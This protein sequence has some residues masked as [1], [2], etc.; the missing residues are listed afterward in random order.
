MTYYFSKRL[1]CGFEEAI[2]RT[3]VA[4]SE[5]G[6]G[7]LTEIDIRATMKAKL[8][9]DLAPYII[10]G[11]CN[12]PLAYEAL[13]AEDK[14]GLM[15]PCNVIVQGAGDGAEVSAIDPAAAMGGIDNPRLQ[16][17]ADKVAGKLK[18]VIAGL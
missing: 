12:P 10:L 3:K 15:L 13:Q 11:A 16:A 9:V 5:A 7:V 17:V 2:D 4:L 8:G 18:A 1:T 14:V 6:F